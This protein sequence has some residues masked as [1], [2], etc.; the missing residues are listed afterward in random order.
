MPISSYDGVI[1]QAAREWNIDP[2]LLRSVIQTES[3]GNPDARSSAGAVGLAQIMPDTAKGLGV[4]DRSDPVQ[5]IFGGAK[6]LSQLLDHYGSA[7]PAI[8]AYNAGPQRVDDYL[9]GKGNLPAETQN[10]VPTVQGHYQ[11]FSAAQPQA[12]QSQGAATAPASGGFGSMSDKDFLSATTGS[13]KSEA[14]A[15]FLARTGAV[16][17]QAPAPS[18]TRPNEPLPLVS[19]GDIAGMPWTTEAPPPSAPAPPAAPDKYAGYD[20]APTPGFGGN[21][22]SPTGP[23]D[24]VSAAINNALQPAPNTTYGAVLP[25]AK[26][27]TTGAMRL[28]LPSSLRD[29]AQ[30]GMDLLQGPALGTVTPQATNTLAA[31]AGGMGES[32]AS[33]TGAAIARSAESKLPPLPS[34]TPLSFSPRAAAARD[35]ILSNTAAPAAK[36]SAAPAGFTSEYKPGS[37]M[38]GYTDAGGNTVVGFVPASPAPGP[39][40]PLNGGKPIEVGA[41][42]VAPAA[43]ADVTAAENIPPKTPGQA[44]RD[45]RSSIEQTAQDRAGPQM[46][47]NQVYVPGVQRPLAAREFTPENS[48]DDKVSRESNPQF[49]AQAEAIDK[50][51]ND[52]M[53]DYFRQHAGD[54]ISIE[55]AQAARDAVN[56]NAMGVFANQKPIDLQP[57]VDK[58]NEILSGPSGKRDA[59]R[60]VLT[61]IQSKLYDADGNLETMP[62]I[63]YGARQNATDKL[64]GSKLTAEGSDAGL[65]RH[66]V[67]TVLDTLDPAITSGAPKFQDYLQQ[68]H[69]LSL[70]IDQM[71]YLQ[72][73]RDKIGVPSGALRP[74]AVQNMLQQ[75]AKD[76]AAIGNNPAKSLTQDQLDA[77]VNLRNETAATQLK[78]NMAKAAGSDTFQKL[79]RAGDTGAGSVGHAIAEGAAHMAL[80]H[81]PLAGTGNVLLGA[82][83]NVVKPAVAASRAKK[84]AAALAQRQHNLL[85]QG[86]ANENLLAP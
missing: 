29:L 67:M 5:S 10:Y 58:I 51:N 42:N 21:P 14:D 53:I 50:A 45:F 19:E 22:L 70:P 57:V 69:D 26:D 27:N 49:R 35:N 2:N 73:F 62:D 13:G 38:T 48:L 15:D 30:G 46:V 83:R 60:N 52:T 3:A 11:R 59:V 44:A 54:E 76:R 85:Q 8:A 6:Y 65:A 66:D 68:W 81:S 39:S 77:L 84:T 74:A 12:P 79:N 61:N 80:W 41:A 32:P 1:Q 20:T 31:V 16:A 63:A 23:H 28:A 36:A 9:A 7:T 37:V 25:I 78:N 17:P 18:P 75:V 43:G 64:K 86:P 40:T 4:T 55:N 47:D 34:D 56:P 71:Q 33:G 82:Y 24:A 72:G